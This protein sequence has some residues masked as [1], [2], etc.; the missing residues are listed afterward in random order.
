MAK[1][2]LGPI[3]SDKPVK[4]ILELPAPI[5]RDLLAYAEIHS[6]HTGNRALEPAKL[7][8][9]MLARFMDTDRAFKRARRQIGSG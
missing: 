5:H 8:P 1:L 9:V 7:I 4:L 3:E 6:H 2:K